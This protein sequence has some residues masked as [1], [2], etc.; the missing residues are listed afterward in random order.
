M[1]SE[2][3]SPLHR[4]GAEAAIVVDMGGTTTR[5]GVYDHGRLTGDLIRFATLKPE[6]GR[7][8][9]ESHLN[10]VAVQVERQRLAHPQLRLRE[11]GLAVGA[12]VDAAGKIRN[13]SML[14]HEAS[15]GFDLVAAMTGRLPWADITV[16]NDIAAAAWRYRN[17][18]RFAIVTV[19]TGVAVK[20]F[21][22][23]LPFDAKLLL[24]GEAL[25]G[26]IGHVRLDV[27]GRGD[28]LGDDTARYR[29][30]GRAAAD[31]DPAAQ[32]A[33]DAAGLP[34]CECGNVADLCSYSSGPATARAAAMHAHA[35]P[36]EWRHSMLHEM[37]DADPGRI[38]TR[39]LVEA[40]ACGDAFTT[41]VLHA[42]TRP[43]AAQILQISALLGLRRFVVMGGFA[44]A[45]GRPWFSALRANLDDLMPGGGWFTGWSAADLDALVIP[46]GDGDDSLIGMGQLMAS[47]RAQPRDLHK[48]TGEARTLVR[49]LSLARCGREQ[50]AA[51]IAFAGVCGTDLQILRGERGCEPGVLGHEGVA[52]V[53]EVGADVRGVV[54]GD[55]IS[56]NPN[57]PSDEHARL[58]HDQPGVFRDI[59][60]WD[61]HMAE[62][63]QIIRLPSE[64]RA[65]WV[66]LEPLACTVR[67]LRLAEEWKGR[68]VLVVGA[69]VSGLLHLLL[70]RQWQA[71]RVLLANRTRDRSAIAVSRGILP[72]D[73]CLQL[74]QDLPG[75]ISEATGGNGVDRVIV[76]VSGGAG[77]AIVENLWPCLADGATVHLFGGFSRSSELRTP[78]G[79]LVACHPIRN[80]GQSHRVQLPDGRTATLVGSRGAGADDFRVARALCLGEETDEPQIQLAP[81]ITH[82]VSLESAPTV[83]DELMAGSRIA[84]EQTLRVVIDLSLT[85]PAIRATD[86]TDLPCLATVS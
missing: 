82:V 29:R 79:D 14:W 49:R 48:P 7:S 46:S 30:L 71:S 9:R 19:S 22:D 47:R 17:L 73:D 28:G 44:Q 20:I 69:G 4:T 57:H 31:G 41:R 80:S 53:T 65:E 21:D 81:L 51:R 74:D 32:T 45:V 35:H 64:G 15:T 16:C 34:W 8:V 26:E 62:R 70:A 72:A 63:G 86:G 25:G 67:S 42:A 2:M 55:V 78:D 50:F 12:T 58:G 27:P 83:L 18:G 37:C 68:Q 61:T 76:S 52:Q 33:L 60:I 66:L 5:V 85:G 77:P 43:L 56:V 54:A 38:T 23:A 24:D 6:P 1:N 11:M 39:V 10:E 59:A 40:A 75:R 3:T 84:G 36:D 13:A